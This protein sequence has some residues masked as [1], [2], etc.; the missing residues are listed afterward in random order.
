MQRPFL[1]GCFSTRSTAALAVL[2][3]AT[4]FLPGAGD[5]PS[6][7]PPQYR[8]LA[9]HP[10][11]PRYFLFRDKPAI[12]ITSGEHYGAVLN[13][14]FDYVRYLD[15]LRAHGL[16]NT[17]TFAGTYREIPGSFGIADNTLAPLPN[18][19]LCPWARTSTPGYFDGG[20]KFDLKRF[21]DA[22]FKRLRDFV[23]QASRRGIVV[24][25]NFFT[26]NYDDKLW[27]A[28]PM[29]ACNNVN[30]VGKCP[31]KEVYTLKHKDLVDVH[32]AVV[33]KIVRE[34]KDFDNLYYE[35]CNEPY[36]GGVTMEWQYRILDAIVA[37]EKDFPHKHLIS[38]NIANGRAKVAKPHPAVSLFNF[39]YCH[40]PDVVA[41]NR[42][43]NKPIG[44]NETGFRGKADVLYRTEGWDFILAGGALY[45]NLD[46]SFT[47]RNPDGSFD[48]FKAPGGGGRTL[49]KQL[50]VLKDFIHGFDFIRLAPDDRVIKGGIPAKATARALVETGKQYAVYIKGGT[51]ADL[52]VELPKGKYA[53]Q[54]LNP[55][56]G[57]IDKSET[58]EHP[59]G[60]ATLRSPKY[61]EDIALS[62]CRARSA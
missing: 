3:L 61:T 38:L 23:A 13:A 20:N 33:R 5:S 57:K 35:V 46:Y 55:R 34:L 31:A 45:N 9:L 48:D 1:T 16:N 43:L 14:D 19:Y 4:L 10:K 12:L 27:K 39:H 30:G 17:R 24:E 22:F 36:F 2:S 25:M 32:E 51:Q 26:P 58:L 50:K 56:A 6:P 37:E 8:P 60:V 59:G 29:N 47:T 62:V 7:K 54:W 15:E 21:D 44:E 42:H 18:R 41:M 40:P 52:R 11:K 28:N 49:R 53:V